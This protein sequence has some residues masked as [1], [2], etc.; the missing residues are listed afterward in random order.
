[1]HFRPKTLLLLLL[2]VSSSSL[3]AQQFGGNPPSLKWKQINTD[4]VRVIFPNGLEKV[5]REIAAIGHQL[6]ATQTT[7][8]NRL[9]KINVVLQNQTTI[10]NGYVGLGP[11]RS[12]FYMTPQQN[13]FELGSIP[14]HQQLALHEFRHVQ[15]FNNF[16]KGLSGVFY[17][18]AGELGVSFANNTALPSYFWEGDAVYQ[19]TLTSEQGRGRMPFFFNGYR[20]LWASGKNYSWMKL[21]SG[22]L[23][24]YVPNHY[25]MG[26]LITA[27]GREKYG[28]DIWGK[29]TNDAVRFRR[30]TY[31]FQAAIKR[32]TGNDYKQF[33]KDALAYFS[34]DINVEADSISKWSARQKHFSG[35]QEFPQWVDDKHLVF[36]SSSFKRIP[37][38]VKRNVETGKEEVIRTRDISLDN[39]FSYR[40]ARVI[41]SAYDPDARWGY[42]DYGE[43]RLLDIN[44]GEQRSI[45]HKTKYFAPD[46]SEDGSKLVAVQ[47]LTDGRSALHIIDAGTGS[48]IKE[49]P[50]K[51]NL[52]YTYP[53]FYGDNQIV[54]AIRNQ[55]GEMAIGLVSM[56]GN[57][58]EWL[59]PFS[60]NV[61]GFINVSKD[62]ISF[63]ASTGEQDKLFVIINKKLYRFNQ[64]N[65]NN[66]TGSYQ[67]NSIG[68]KIVWVDFTSAGYRYVVQELAPSSLEEISSETL[69]APLPLFG[70]NSL[71][72]S[73]VKLQDSI[74]GNYPVKK[75]R[76]GFRLLNF[77]SWLPTISDPEYTLSFISENI[78]NTLQTDVYFTYN[79]N[80]ESK[81]FGFVT[82]YGAL[83]PWLRAG[84]AY[85]RDLPLGRLNDSLVMSDQW[86]VRTGVL[87]PLNLTKGRTYST[88]RIGTDYVYANTQ[89]T[90]D[91]KDRFTLDDYGYIN[92]YAT[93]SVQSQQAVQHIY[94]RFGEVLILNYH[95]GV[96]NV[97]R[98]KFL[99]NS[100]SYLPGVHANHNFVINAAW[101]QMDSSGVILY[102]NS[103]PFS[104]GYSATNFPSGYQEHRQWKL[105]VNY[106]LPLV[107]P[108]WGFGNIVYFLRI[109]ANAFYDFTRINGFN[110][111][112]KANLAY[113]YRSYGGELFFDTKWWNQQPVSFGFRYSRLM[114]GAQ[115]GLG[116]NQFEFILPVNIISR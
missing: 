2:L 58:I 66:A 57:G 27:Y 25:Q 22:S 16:R 116:P 91:F 105:G 89:I 77:H 62:T 82:A 95:Q 74:G 53:K 111:T 3:I 21:R 36:V 41:Y 52:Y 99:A 54:S 4:T 43:I 31:P 109:R 20:S 115:Q 72:K 39:Y 8:G 49:I 26:Y 29:V 33:R 40:N 60:M 12:E 23:R 88:L 97:T 61:I 14:W 93:L 35:D 81:K 18:L 71:Q 64:S 101:Q 104:R 11:Y 10:S 68:D 34:Q 85:T 15:Q 107:Y 113:D 80:E 76:K 112:S 19:E 6:G 46:I 63:T 32:H 45:T 28:N 102:S 50:N 42:R 87:V 13:S 59:T 51:D 90:G 44:T 84:A 55:K 78:L 75:Y 100:Y 94:P 92:S 106:H 86:E 47:V 38:F 110:N 17:V 67:L 56:D 83:F 98:K 114:D 96:Q 103:F 9:R 69:Q 65:P 5:A 73:N 70:I 48:V 24:D 1:M 30:L 37:Q 108:D 79:N 7:L